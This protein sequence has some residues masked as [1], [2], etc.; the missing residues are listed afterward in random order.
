MSD[1]F[2]DDFTVELKNFFLNSVHTELE[3]YLNAAD[4]DTWEIF[5]D[6]LKPMIE[7]WISDSQSNEFI[8]FSSWLRQLKDHCVPENMDLES[9]KSAL[10]LIQQYQAYLF[11]H[12]KDSPEIAHQLD[13]LGIQNRAEIYLHCSIGDQEFL[14][15]AG[16]VLQVL[17]ETFVSELPLKKER[18]LGMLPFRGDAIPVLSLAVEDSREL[19]RK[20]KFFIVC[21]Q[22]ASR[23]A[24]PVSGADR[25]IEVS[26]KDKQKV[27]ESA[28]GHL[29]AHFVTHYVRF[30]EKNML[31]CSLEKMVAA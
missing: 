9:F 26:Q 25:L 19:E 17:G 8:H 24:L 21:E 10:K 29:M 11:K 5:C 31:V 22:G 1:F 4:V 2:G 7:S 13:I 15:P 18:L 23:F 12:K 16:Q 3:K 28:A 14:V 6:E 20:A 30:E 27:N